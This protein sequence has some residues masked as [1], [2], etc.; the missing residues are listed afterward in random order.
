[1]GWSR[2]EIMVYT[3]HLRRHISDPKVQAWFLRRVVYGR[4]PE[5]A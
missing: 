4:K 2:P 5:T 3:A 1:M